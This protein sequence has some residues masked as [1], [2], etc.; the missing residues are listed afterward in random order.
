MCEYIPKTIETNP[1]A[2]EWAST[3]ERLDCMQ[4][5]LA[6]KAIN[7]ILFEAEMGNL[8]RDSVKIN[9]SNE[10]VSLTQRSSD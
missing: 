8:S 6:K 5:L 3:L 7:D 9:E 2:L 1:I 10:T 4:R